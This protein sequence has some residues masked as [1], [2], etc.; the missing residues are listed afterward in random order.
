MQDSRWKQNTGM[1][2]DDEKQFI[3]KLSS[4]DTDLDKPEIA[5]EFAR[6]LM[7]HERYNDARLI[8]FTALDEG[9]RYDL[10]ELRACSTHQ[11]LER[12]WVEVHEALGETPEKNSAGIYN[13]GARKQDPNWHQA[14]KQLTG[15]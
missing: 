9:P 14:L 6:L 3:R 5:V 15:S 8:I 4:K 13:E 11:N 1:A 7:A 12:L 10:Y 2:M